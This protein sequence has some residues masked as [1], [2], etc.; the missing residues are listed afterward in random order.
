MDEEL[1]PDIDKWSEQCASF[2]RDHAQHTLNE[3]EALECFIAAGCAEG[4][5]SL[6]TIYGWMIHGM[7]KQEG[8][9]L[10]SPVR[11]SNEY[12]FMVYDQKAGK[13]I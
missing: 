3:R 2:L 13:Y 11:M 5:E 4:I 6:G 10:V 8:D 7:G 12:L 1:E 9:Y